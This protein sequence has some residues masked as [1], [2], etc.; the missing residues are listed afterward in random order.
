MTYYIDI[1]IYIYMCVGVCV[2]VYVRA[3]VH[4]ICTFTRQKVGFIKLGTVYVRGML[5]ERVGV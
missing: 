4:G 5:H 3:Y 1:N 2:C